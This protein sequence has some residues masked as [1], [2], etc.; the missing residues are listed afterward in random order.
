MATL[1]P[2][3]RCYGRPG[4][5]RPWTAACRRPFPATGTTMKR[6]TIAGTVTAVALAAA[7]FLPAA[8]AHP[9]GIARDGCHNHRASDTCHCHRPGASR[10]GCTGWNEGGH[11]SNGGAEPG[12]GRAPSGASPP[13]AGMPPAPA[14]W[15]RIAT[16]NLNRLHWRTGGALWRGASARDDEDYA[17]LARYARALDADVIAFQ[18]VNGPRAAARVFPS[19]DY[20]LYFSGRYDSRYDDIYNGFAVR[21]DRFDHVEKRDYEALGLGSGA[22]YQLRWGVDLTV[23]RDGQSLRLLNVHLK[24]KC[25]AKSLENPRDRHCRKLARQIDPLESWIDARWSEGAPFVVLGDFN[26][27]V[28]RHGSRDHLWEAIDDGDPPGLKLHRLPAGQEPACWRGTS[29]HH[30]HPIDFFVFGA[31]AWR[32]VD[33]TSFR[34][35]VW[36]DADADPRRGLPS[37]HC[38]IAVDLF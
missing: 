8:S 17:V 13:P 34:Q 9:G 29:R 36:T 18:E 12:A 24:S 5:N 14:E 32:R 26:R 11:G 4:T 30:R 2:T 28:D 7:A 1:L 6:R 31:R 20:T 3:C 15:I 35:I 27:A 10:P 19:R 25:F 37:D 33:E 16:W 38:P 22:R 21:K 23:R